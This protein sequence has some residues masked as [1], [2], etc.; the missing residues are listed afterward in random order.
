MD[1]QPPPIIRQNA[2]C[3]LELGSEY[4][5]LIRLRTNLIANWKCEWGEDA[6]KEIINNS[7]ISLDRIFILINK[8]K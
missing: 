5:N 1:K 8:I 4:S 7:S 6:R 2:T 3:F